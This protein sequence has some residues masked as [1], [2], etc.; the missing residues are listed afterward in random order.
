MN[1]GINTAA[2]PAARTA[3]VV[4]GSSGIGCETVLRLTESGWKVFNISR[5]PC[6]NI[7]VN[8]ICA[9][10]TCDKAF[11][12]IKRISEENGLD[13]LI[14]S[15]GCSMAA[16]VEY[17]EERDYR[18][19]FEVN[20]FGALKSVQAALPYMKKSG[21]KIILIGSLGGEIPIIFDIQSCPRDVGARLKA[22]TYGL[23][24][25]RYRLSSRR[26]GY[27]VHIQKKDLPRGRVR[28]LRNQT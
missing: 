5:T 20:F 11:E 25:K 8:N 3:I 2:K 1:S 28:R 12:E 13:L 16:P 19:L 23:R 26:N 15:A 18:Y 27:G 17:A 14:Y 24:H 22:G 6:I 9:D 21:G 4:G 7:K 10:V